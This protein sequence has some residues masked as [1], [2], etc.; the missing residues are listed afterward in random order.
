M[1]KRNIQSVRQAGLC[2]SCGICAANCPANCITFSRENGSFYPVVSDACLDCGRCLKV[3]SSYGLRY[4]M[5]SQSLSDYVL[6]EYQNIMCA[7]MKDAS[8][9]SRSASGGMATGIIE[10]LLGAGV[11]ESAFLVSG[12]DYNDMLQ[13]KRFAKDNSLDSTVGSRYLT[14]SHEAAVRYMQGHP[15]EKTIL[16]ATG[17]CVEGLVKSIEINR[18][19]REN[20]LLIGLFCDR[21]MHYGAADYFYEH[22]RI[23]RKTVGKLFFRSKKDSGWPGNLRIEYTNG[24][25]L[26][27]PSSERKQI[28]DYFVPERCLYCLDKLNRHCDLALGDNYIREN[29]D[30]KGINSCIIRTDRGRKAWDLCA[31]GFISHADDKERLLASQRIADKKTNLSFA[32]LKGLYVSPQKPSRTV[33]HAYRVTLEKVEVGKQEHPYRPVM[34]DIL[35]RRRKQ[36]IANVIQRLFFAM[37]KQYK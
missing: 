14:V 23:G 36:R 13:T 11:F 32:L 8:A 26:Q 22:P 35:W 29:A 19:E 17:C 30:P 27:L 24:S 12:Y 3:C 9:L 6:G 7:Q 15:E 31:D 20:Y 33:K 18:L 4:D 28:K 21:T 16:V 37:R 2:I 1:H 5:G 34:Y 10:R 25:E